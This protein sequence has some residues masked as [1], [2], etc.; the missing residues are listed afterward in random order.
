VGSLV[1]EHIIHSEDH[2]MNDHKKSHVSLLGALIIIVLVS[3][4]LV[5]AAYIMYLESPQK[6]YDLARPGNS[7]RNKVLS[8]ED[9][10]SDKTTPID[11]QTTKVKIDALN[12]Q[13]RVMAGFD[14]FGQDEINDQSLGLQP[15]AQ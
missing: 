15:V 14:S 2:D 6:K 3:L 10:S 5:T 9:S 7:L 4:T 11:P 1:S 8:A 13:L 12:V